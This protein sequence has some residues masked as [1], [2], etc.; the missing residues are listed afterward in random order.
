M[1]QHPAPPTTPQRTLSAT[2]W[3]LLV[4]ILVALLTSACQLTPPVSVSMR[5]SMVGQGQVIR[6]TNTSEEALQEVR[7]RVT[8]PDSGESREHFES[9][10]GPGGLL[11]VGWLKLEGWP[12]PEGAEV[13]VTAKGFAIAAKF[14]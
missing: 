1:N 9:Q 11:E 12:V 6:I 3:A 13:A 8:D 10:L 4:P 7:V 14:E 5:E 2:R